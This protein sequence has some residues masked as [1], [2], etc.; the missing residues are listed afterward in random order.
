MKRFVLFTTFVMGL[1][2]VFVGCGS[3]TGQTGVSTDA[4]VESANEVDSNTQSTTPAD[5]PV[6]NDVVKK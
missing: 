4:V 2:F 6:T 1:A 5:V 3:K